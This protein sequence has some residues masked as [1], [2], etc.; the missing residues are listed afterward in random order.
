M[1]T[2]PTLEELNA[3]LSSDLPTKHE[4]FA[5]RFPSAKAVALHLESQFEEGMTWENAGTYWKIGLKDG[6]ELPEGDPVRLQFI[7]PVK[8]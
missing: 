3:A 4:H 2:S 1:S 8:V 7:R 6:I 5:R